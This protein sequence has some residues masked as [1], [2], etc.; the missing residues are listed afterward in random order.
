MKKKL[1]FMSKNKETR[2]K[3]KNTKRKLNTKKSVESE[4]I[5]DT[6]KSKN[7]DKVNQHNGEVAKHKSIVVRIA[8]LVYMGILITVLFVGVLIIPYIKN[9]LQQNISTSMKDVTT[10]LGQSFDK[11]I[12]RSGAN[13]V[14]TPITLRNSLASVKVNG[15]K[16]SYMYIINGSGNVAWHPNE[17]LIGEKIGISEVQ[18]IVD[19]M[20]AKE[21]VSPGFLDYTYNGEQK[22]AVYF[23]SSTYSFTLVLC[24]D[25][26][27]I[28][29]PENKV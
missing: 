17:K 7:E 22:H 20:V 14:L 24:C 11:Q 8:G 25:K 27:E 15:L 9:S 21:K 13:I 12:D 18:N 16:S 19:K 10:I 23:V 4:N 29:A 26:S 28:N 3:K 6:D 2:T 1:D 5:Q